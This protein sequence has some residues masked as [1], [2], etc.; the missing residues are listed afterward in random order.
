MTSEI[1]HM[2]V[3]IGGLHNGMVSMQS[4]LCPHRLY[5]TG[6]FLVPILISVE[7]QSMQLLTSPDN[8]PITLT[9]PDS[10]TYLTPLPSP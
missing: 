4:D 8:T 2:H 9:M 10:L 1:T 3:H 5:L 6:F 7:R